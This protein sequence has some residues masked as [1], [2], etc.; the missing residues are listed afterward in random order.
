MPPRS[1]RSALSDRD[2]P[3]ISNSVI[4]GNTVTASTSTGAATIQGAGL[5]NNGLLE[6]RNVRITRNTA[7]ETAPTGF[8]QGGGIWNGVLFDPPPVQLVLVNTRVAEN[9]ITAT[10]GVTIQ[11]AGLFTQFP[12][13][14]TNSRIEG[15]APDDCAGC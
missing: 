12:V 6:L 2:S 13:T 11:G 14:L 4:D 1:E 7:T 5:A 3:L 9:T 8:A 10:P 15:N